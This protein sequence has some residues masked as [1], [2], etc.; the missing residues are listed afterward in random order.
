MNTMTRWSK[1][2]WAGIAQI[3]LLMSVAG[4]DEAS[5]KASEA[6]IA[7]VPLK[8]ILDEER[9]RDHPANV[10]WVS[11]EG[12]IGGS[13]FPALSS[14]RSRIALLHEVGTMDDDY[15][16]FEVW[17]TKP[18]KLLRRIPLFPCSTCAW[19]DVSTHLSEAAKAI[20]HQLVEVNHILTQGGYRPME[21]FFDFSDWKTVVAEKW[22]MSVTVEPMKPPADGDVLRVRSLQGGRD[23]LKL[24][25]PAVYVQMGDDPMNVCGSGHYPRKGWY[26]PTLRVAV[27]QLIAPGSRDGCER[28]E[29]WILKR[30][31]R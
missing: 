16:I 1:W 20:K 31:A 4:A 8:I 15:P 13:D 18:P 12:G 2:Q 7:E 30:L 28:P 23:L 22:G 6:K 26:D 19:K 29:R 17:S 14:D 3:F 25:L 9:R 5:P 21:G 27:I 10:T 24:K 11:V